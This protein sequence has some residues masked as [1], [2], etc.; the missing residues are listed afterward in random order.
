MD[1]RSHSA[2]DDCYYCVPALNCFGAYVGALPD[3]SVLFAIVVRRQR[4][5]MLRSTMG[6]YRCYFVQKDGATIAWHVVESEND[7]AARDHA[8]GL[9][10]GYANA[11]KVE[12]WDNISLILRYCRPEAQTPAEMR[13]LCYLAIAAANKEI[14]AELRKM[15]ASRA[16]TLAQEAEAL[17]RHECPTTDIVDLHQN[18]SPISR[19][20][21]RDS[22]GRTGRR[23]PTA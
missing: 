20:N 22:F 18:N 17:E 10:V 13:R 6:I 23:K 8:L 19:A 3:S 15:V 9:F 7:G 16:A 11:E 1:I 12:V 4:S 14:D 21:L 2:Y 5:S